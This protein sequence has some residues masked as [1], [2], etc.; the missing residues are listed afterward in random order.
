[1]S[2][3]AGVLSIHASATTGE[4]LFSDAQSIREFRCRPF[5][6]ASA[7][8]SAGPG[9]VDALE[10][11]PLGWIGQ[12]LESVLASRRVNAA[13][14]GIL[15]GRQAAELVRDLLREFG[16]PNLVLAPVY[17]VSGAMIFP[18]K[19]RDAIRR[20]LY[21]QAAVLVVR[22]GDLDL[23]VGG[24]PESLREMQE[25]AGRLREQ[26][27]GA[28]LVCGG[29]I[30]GRVFD[31]LDD[32]GEVTAFGATRLQV[33]RLDGLADAHTAALA[34][35]LARGLDLKQAVRAAQRYV[36]IR[37]QRGR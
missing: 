6:V 19:N 17:R 24:R 34:C 15:P 14:V 5:P 8:L 36:A 26:G 37:L 12:Q 1:M 11:L 7:V 28:V 16:V 23:A 35:H 18:E 13:K 9:G 4:G 30:K 29:L 20:V 25:G 2:E 31:L 3:A 22:A 10:P 27:A 32:H 33:P 21:P